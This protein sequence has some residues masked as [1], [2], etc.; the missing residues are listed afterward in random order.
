MASLAQ[1]A[2][3]SRDNRL[4]FHGHTVNYVTF[5]AVMT[6]PIYDFGKT[7]SKVDIARAQETISQATLNASEQDVQV[8]VRVAYF[9]VLAAQ[10]AVEVAE[11][12]RQNQVRHTEQIRHFVEAGVVGPSMTLVS[13]ELALDDAEQA[14]MHAQVG[15]HKAQVK[16]NQS[17][18]LDVAA[19]FEVVGAYDGK[20]P[21]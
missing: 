7:G 1:S 2:A 15:L 18:G 14:L 16:L 4:G 9:A 5:G 21:D 19:A 12:T 3:T 6:Q 20:L 17:I 11:E 8:A 13:A 10:Q